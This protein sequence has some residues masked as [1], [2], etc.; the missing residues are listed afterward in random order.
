MPMI[1]MKLVILVF[2]SVEGVGLDFSWLLHKFFFLYLHETWDIR[3]FR[4]ANTR[5]DKWSAGTSALQ[6]ARLV[7][8]SFLL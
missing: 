8:G 7:S 1:P 5:S 2:V 3:V 4:G 6:S